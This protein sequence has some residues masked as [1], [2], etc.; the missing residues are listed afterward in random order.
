MLLAFAGFGG[1]GK[2]SAIQY[3]EKQGLGRRVYL[4]DA[5]FEELDRRHLVRSPETED[6]VRIELRSRLGAGAFAELKANA[7]TELIS[8]GQC[9][10]ID[11]IFAPE[12]YETLLNC[13]GQARSVLIGIEASFD[14]RSRRV[15]ARAGRGYTA[16]ELRERDRTETEK[17]RTER[18]LEMAE[19][20][21][22]NERSLDDFYL[23]VSALW[24]RIAG[25]SCDS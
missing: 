3:L 23:E 2:T 15:S 8:A 4:G 19:F 12:E 14:M 13:C 10:F 6:A 7:V 16:E 17:L 9:V 1:A 21:I 18:V 25:L 11:A 5:V 22:P 20:T 24:R